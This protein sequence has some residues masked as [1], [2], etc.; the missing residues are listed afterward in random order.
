MDDLLWSVEPEASPRRRRLGDAAA[1]IE[2]SGT[3]IAGWR[4]ERDQVLT[5]VDCHADAKDGMHGGRP[6][7]AD[8]PTI[9]SGARP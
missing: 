4:E 1:L 8:Q 5:L 6:D 7:A 9:A 2:P 3:R